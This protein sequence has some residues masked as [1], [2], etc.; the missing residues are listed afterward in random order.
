MGRSLS[1]LCLS[2]DP[3]SAVVISTSP[4]M[5]SVRCSPVEWRIF[6][7]KPWLSE[8]AFLLSDVRRHEGEV[9]LGLEPGHEADIFES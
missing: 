1:A 3:A 9:R 2:T 6:T 5:R 8:V 4:A 7:F